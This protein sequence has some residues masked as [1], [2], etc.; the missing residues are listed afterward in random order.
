MVDR[1]GGSGGWQRTVGRVLGR[2]ACALF[3]A[4]IGVSDGMATGDDDAAPVGRQALVVGVKSYSDADIDDVPSGIH[5]ARLVR[6][7]LES[8]DF[9]VTLV[10]DPDDAQLWSSLFAF[11]GSIDPGDAVV[12][13]FSGHGFQ[14][15]GLNYLAPTNLPTPIDTDA[16]TDVVLPLVTVTDVLARV[17]PGFSLFLIDACRDNT[18]VAQESD[19]TIKSLGGGLHEPESSA[20]Q[21][22]IGFAAGFGDTALSASTELEPSVFTEHLVERLDD[23]GD[24]IVHILRSTAFDVEADRP[25]QSPELR[26]FRAGNF[27][28]VGD[29]D[30]K[31]L[32]REA[33]RL[34]RDTGN[35]IEVR[36][37][38]NWWPVSD[39]AYAARRWLE[40]PA[41][42]PSFDRSPGLAGG[43]RALE[44][45]GSGRLFREGDLRFAALS[46]PESDIS[47][48]SYEAM[49]WTAL[50][51][52][53]EPDTA[54]Y[55]I[56]T[57]EPGETLRIV[58]IEA[59]ID[60]G[61]W[62]RNATVAPGWSKVRFESTSQELRTGYV[63]AQLE[64]DVKSIDRVTL[65]LRPATQQE[66]RAGEIEIES[67]QRWGFLP[68]ASLS[69]HSRLSD[70]PT[71]VAQGN[72]G[73][74]SS[75]ELPH[76]VARVQL[77]SSVEGAR[78]EAEAAQLSFVRGHQIRRAL[79]DAGLEPENI[80]VEFPAE[81]KPNAKSS[82][83]E[84]LSL[85]V[86]ADDG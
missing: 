68:D 40:D 38:L 75:V 42:I 76:S 59:K 11:A 85:A 6:D 43:V 36:H 37:F 84:R 47:D 27:H 61:G 21:L 77:S 45:V 80:S 41:N 18:A 70:L 50:E 63:F 3:F 52:M 24:D 22:V 23:P 12:F 10:E 19:G 46:A 15:Q 72:V 64:A 2:L 82:R 16:L 57:I 71:L 4:T 58:E 17:H 26:V 73:S 66:I 65:N 35:P 55:R 31:G 78:S 9:N 79:I 25:E 8:I 48:A 69:G 30:S 14:W 51:L 39:Y 74:I 56:D 32:A 83:P 33:W 5:D 62:F 53:H 28:P 13:Y 49:A 60:E 86:L 81:F 54:S 44:G 29:R 1:P 20:R 34:A 7:V 67:T